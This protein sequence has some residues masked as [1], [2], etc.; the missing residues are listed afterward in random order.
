[1]NSSI[2]SMA[3]TLFLLMDPIGNIPIYLSVLQD[4]KPS[5]RI[6]IILRESSIA[7]AIILLF[8]LIGNPLLDA[9][10]IQRPTLFVAGG[11][12]LFLMAIHM[13]FPGNSSLSEK[14]NPDKS[15]PLI[16]P[17]AVPLVAGP[18]IL[19]MVMVYASRQIHMFSIIISIFLAWIASTFILLSSTVMQKILSEKGVKAL[20]RLMGLILIL[21]SVQMIFNGV[22][23]Y[24]TSK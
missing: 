6:S 24:I 10:S 17:L 21:L 15:E 9:L 14:F 16:F 13:I 19:A 20:E 3:F 2:F 18:A 4:I 8:T 1:M 22:G 23:T 11:V 7:L 5:K 12:I